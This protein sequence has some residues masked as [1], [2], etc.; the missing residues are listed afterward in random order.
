MDVLIKAL[1]LF[2]LLDCFFIAAAAAFLSFSL[3]RNFKNKTSTTRRKKRKCLQ[4][5]CVYPSTA[6]AAAAVNGE[7]KSS[8]LIFLTSWL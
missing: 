2:H 8:S 3:C 7:D 6:A 5:V 4:C 1:F